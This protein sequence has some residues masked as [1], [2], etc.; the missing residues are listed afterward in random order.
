VSD[1]RPG[2][3]WDDDGDW[4]TGPSP[5]RSIVDLKQPPESD[6]QRNPI[7]AITARKARRSRDIERPLLDTGFIAHTLRFDP[8]PCGDEGTVT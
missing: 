8:L 7:A 2:V 4:E 6:K 1:G 3:V 5:G